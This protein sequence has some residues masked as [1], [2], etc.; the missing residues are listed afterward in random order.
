[1]QDAEFVSRTITDGSVDLDKFPASRVRQ[2]AKKVDSSKA[3]AHHIKWVA[4]D[5]QAAQINLLTHQHTELPA[6]KYKKKRPPVKPK[7]S[8]HKQQSSESYHVQARHK[9]RFD[10]KSTHNNKDRCSKCGDAAHIEGFQCPVK[11]TSAK[12]AISLDILQA[13]VSRKS[14][15]MSNPEDPKH[16][17]CKQVQFMQK[18]V[19]YMTTQMRIALVKIH[20]PCN[21][22]SNASR[23]KNE[24][25]QD[26]HI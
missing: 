11:N 10:P 6:G 25:C 5:P 16:I 21:S 22:R 26:Q 9:K 1:M 24:K 2:L 4:G 17:S 23:I 15:L 13:C 20:F 19:T 8:N 7:Q 18:K 3:T 14:K 12:L